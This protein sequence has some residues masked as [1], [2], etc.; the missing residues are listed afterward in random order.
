V[1]AGFGWVRRVAHLLGRK[2]LTGP[3]VRRRLRGLVG[4]MRAE[5][6]RAEARGDAGLADGLRHFVKVTGSYEPGLFACYDVAQVPRT[7]NDLEHLFGSHRYHERRASGRKV[8]SP[9]LVVRG[10]VRLVAGLATRLQPAH[11]ADLAPSDV[12]AW[13]RLRRNLQRRRDARVA[14]RRFRHDPEAY[15]AQLERNLIQPTMPA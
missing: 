2:D 3:Q 15:L 9:G 10:A 11:G 8:A 7:N 5:A 12:D 4:R 6:G 1:Q 14:R 13:R